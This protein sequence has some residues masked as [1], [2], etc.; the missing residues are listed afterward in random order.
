MSVLF[1]HV[2][3]EQGS[4]I[5]DLRGVTVRYGQRAALDNIS[6]SL[7]VGDRVA[8]V[9]PNGAGKS[10]LFKTIAGLLDPTE[11]EVRVFGHRPVGHICIAYVPQRSAVDW[12][13][14]ATV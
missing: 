7:G 1:N 5:L 6:F 3:H 4:P 14:P 13:F 11:G 10:T 12:T 2:P 9:G 8:V